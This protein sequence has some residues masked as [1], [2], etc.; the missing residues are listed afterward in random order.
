MNSGEVKVKKKIEK[1]SKKYQVLTPTK[2]SNYFLKNKPTEL[3][4]ELKK[5]I[6]GEKIILKGKIIKRFPTGEEAQSQGRSEEIGAAS[7]VGFGG[8]MG[9]KIY[10]ERD[11]VIGDDNNYVVVTKVP[12]LSIEEGQEVIILGYLLMT[13]E[14][15]KVEC[16]KILDKSAKK[17]RLMNDK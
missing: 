6:I 5:S 9:V 8:S 15:M 16:I 10:F 3:K 12:D 13:R 2:L 11:Y 7:A 4:S 1:L 14:K 17:S